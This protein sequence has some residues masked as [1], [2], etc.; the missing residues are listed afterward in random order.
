MSSQIL[1]LDIRG[2]YTSPN[3]LSGSPDG[4]LSAAD[5]IVIPAT[6]LARSRNG[7]RQYGS[8]LSGAVNKLFL[9]SSN[10]L[11]NY[12]TKLAYDSDGAGT[13]VDYSGTY[14]PFAAGYRMQSLEAAGCAYFT[15][16]KGIYKIDQLVTTPIPAGVSTGLGISGSTTG[17]SG[18][19]LEDSAV[20][21]RVVWGYIDAQNTLLLGAPSQRLTVINPAGSGSSKD[22]ALTVPIPDGI[23]TTHFVR[24]YRS[25]GTATD[26]DTPNDDLQL[27]I[28]ITPSSGEIAAHVLTT[29]DTTPY[30]LMRE[31]LYT[32]QGIEGAENANFPPPAALDFDVFKGSTFYA[33]TKQRQ[34]LSITLI[35]VG[36]PQLGYYDDAS[37]GTTSA[38]PNLTT[39]ASTAGLRVGMRCVGTGIPSDS[40]IQEI[41]SA[42]TLTM[43]KNATATAS[44]AVQFQ[45]GISFGTRSY[46]AGST[47]SYTTDQFTAQ[48]GLSP[49]QNINETALNL[50]DV[51]NRST[52]GPV[53]GYY[54]SGTDDLPGVFRIE[55][56]ELG[57][58][59]LIVSSTLS[60]CWSPALNKQR[61]IS[62][63]TVANPTVITSPL[64]GLTTGNSI[65]I[66][67]SNS[68][69]AL[70]GTYT[71]T[72]VN[73]NTFTVPVNV[74]VAGTA[75]YWN[76]STGLVTTN[77]EVRQNRVYVSKPNQ[78][79]AVPV[80]R[81]FD[82]GSAN[83]PIQRVKA[84]RDGIIFFKQDGIFRIT[85]ETFVNMA[86]TVLDST[87]VL[88]AP[89]SVA[90][91][92]NQIFCMTSQ[93][94]VSVT[95]SGVA[96]RS[97]PIEDAVLLLSS[98]QYPAFPTVSF[99]IGY[100]SERTYAF[101]TVTQEDDDTCTQAFI[102]NSLTNAW[103]RW[104]LTR[105][106]GVVNGYVDKLYMADDDGQVFV[107]RKNFT[108]NDYADLEYAVTVVSVDDSTT[109]TILAQTGLAVGQTLVQSRRQVLITAVND[110]FTEIEV[111]STRGFVA[112]AATAYQPIRNRMEWHPIT[113]GNPGVLKHFSEATFFF[114]D[115][116][117]NTIEVGFASN[118]IK[119]WVHFPLINNTG[120]GWGGQPWGEFP[121]GGVL[122]GSAA[123][124]T[125]WPRVPARGSWGYIYLETEQAFQGF[126]LQGVSI[127]FTEMSSRF[128]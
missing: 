117:F 119:S 62:S 109:L 82:I 86:V 51:I 122:G 41:T 47:T 11:V 112:G 46:W 114:K 44:V 63:N 103:T 52:S 17:G 16:S 32:N 34:Q 81:Y 84:L 96:I 68:T 73:A 5:N 39:I 69:P 59:A 9:Y 121:W 19:L 24:I 91:L 105:S 101:F 71:V 12:G 64:H 74:T 77:A 15:T 120:V 115:A 78:P 94:I 28:Q 37:V 65:Q 67:G 55:E 106:A 25:F 35:A 56:R 60:T 4:A 113:G 95:D 22:V 2:L 8:P 48:I 83:F 57:G 79:E 116:A 3:N 30:S 36:L 88:L 21:Y 75:G 40:R 104:D 85:G 26:G 54:E 50:I 42:T 90:T 108:N 125:Y 107:E 20:A 118:I 87:V 126:S 100:E 14:S 93:G 10:L 89:E 128:R 80:Y 23:T 6:N 33:N 124:R 99:G 31:A 43:S 49:G 127:L 110:A 76:L 97:V 72:V 58:D 29:T 38:S 102:Y 123:L 70:S 1:N 66:Y 53:Y 98:D 111:T 7:Q 92:A 18:F 13:F 27:V 61:L 45:D